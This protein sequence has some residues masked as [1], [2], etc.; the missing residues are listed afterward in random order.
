ME[1][2]EQGH[3]DPGST[4]Q[5]EVFIEQTHELQTLLVIVIEAFVEE[6]IRN[7]IAGCTANQKGRV[8]RLAWKTT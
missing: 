3:L 2:E 6:N 1:K 8:K 5:V 4:Q 7:D